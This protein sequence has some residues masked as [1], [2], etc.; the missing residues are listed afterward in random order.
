MITKH[1]LFKLFLAVQF[2][3]LFSVVNSA[4]AKE[5]QE[6]KEDT[7]AEQPSVPLLPL[8]PDSRVLPTGNVQVVPYVACQACHG[9]LKP[10]LLTCG[11]CGVVQP[12]ETPEMYEEYVTHT[13]RVMLST[14]LYWKSTESKSGSGLRGGSS[15]GVLFATGRVNGSQ[16]VL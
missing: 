3:L 5:E 7:R 15:V 11:H 14:S 10:G 9:L 12:D 2:A 16:Q 1:I 13:A 6:D 4:Y 8:L